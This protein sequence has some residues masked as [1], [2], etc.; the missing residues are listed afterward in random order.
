MRCYQKKWLQRLSTLTIVLSTPLLAASPTAAAQEAEPQPTTRDTTKAYTNDI[1]G[2]LTPGRGF[3]IIRTSRGSLNIS[4]YGL[5]RYIHQNPAGQLFTDHLGRERE[6]KPRNDLNWH[7][8]FAWLTGFF[9]DPKFRYNITLWSLGTTQQAL[10]FGNL[11]YRPSK[12]IGFSAGIAPNLTARSMQGSW[13]YWAASDRQMAEE[14]FRGGFSS[15]FWISGEVLPRLAYNVSVNNNISQ[16]GVT[17]ANDT[18]D[19]MYSASLRWQPTTG[20]FGP[21]NGF[22][23]LEHHER[24]ATQF[25]LSAATGREGRYAPLG[26]PPNATQIK[27][28]DGVNP[29]EEGALADGVTVTTLSYKVLALDAGAKYRGFSFQSEYYFRTLD[30][31]VATGPVPLTSIYDHG[32]MAEAM[33]MVVRGK[34]G[35][36]AVSGY[37][38]DDFDRQPWELGGGANYYPSGTR[39][40]RLNAHVLHVHRSPA[41]SFFGYYLSGQTGTIF[42][43]GIDLLL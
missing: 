13:P 35:L 22:G 5:F 12:A 23:D 43:L 8:T 2:E 11:Q 17:Q 7:R 33:H 42:S 28:S 15:G 41:S 26:S 10:L 37:V 38:F 20:E 21:R 3:D 31:F 30:D 25:G 9:Y 34:L 29:F 19:M 1:A 16:L 27:L 14:F 40:L 6:V 32:F 24:L 18:R 39:T 4:V 36:Y